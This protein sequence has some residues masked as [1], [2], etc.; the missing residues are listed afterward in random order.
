M[1]LTTPDDDRDLPTDAGLI[2]L[3]VLPGEGYLLGGT[4]LSV[5]AT[6]STT[7]NDDAQSLTFQWGLID[8][9]ED[10]WG[11][12]D[13]YLLNISDQPC[14]FGSQATCSPGP[15]EGTFYYDYDDARNFFVDDAYLEEGLPAHFR[16]SRRVSDRDKTATFTIRVSHNRAVDSPRHD[17]WLTDPATGD[18]Y[19]DFP[20]TLTGDQHQVIGR[21]EILDNGRPDP[22]RWSYSAQLLTLKDAETGEAL[23]RSQER[24]Y[25]TVQGSRTQ[26]VRPENQ[27]WPFIDIAMATPD[28]VDEGQD[29]TFSIRRRGGNPLADLDVEVR[30][31]EPNRNA[32]G[33]TNPTEQFHTVTFA[34]ASMTDKFVKSVN[35]VQTFTVTVNDDADFETSDV[36]RAELLGSVGRHPNSRDA[37]QVTINKSDQPTITLTADETSINEG[38][39]VTFT[40]TRGT[41][42]AG[43]LLVGVRVD[44]PG[45]FL[46]GDYPGDPEGVETP[47]SVM[48]A[49]GDTTKTVT[50]TPPDDRRDIADS[51]L[52]FTVEADPGYEILGTNPQTVQVADND[53]AP[54]VQISFNH[55]EVAEGEELILTIT[56]I[57]E[58][59]NDLEIPML[60]GPA[61]DQ[62]LMV[63][64]MDP[65]QSE[66]YFRYLLPDDDR[67]GPD[68]EYSFTLQPENLEFWTP[69]GDTTVSARIVDN[70]PYRVSVR[71]FRASVDEGQVIYYRVEHDGYTD[72]P[73]Q[74]K[75]N[76]SEEGSAVLDGIL[77][78]ETHT[79]LAGTSGRTRGTI[80][81]PPT[82]AT[83]T[84]SSPSSW[85]R[86]PPT[87]SLR[88]APAP[89]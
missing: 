47:T 75:V 78:P 23:P 43:D 25:W 20:L 11:T 67:K 3:N 66:S 81:T 7:D 51:S 46:Q 22:G 89:R 41:N 52:T 53:V 16:V 86:T 6:I 30:T 26:S 1:S 19:K 44:D 70:D 49:D 12:G 10:D 21:I 32:P 57:G 17:D 4:G 87:K 62:H 69:T 40:L 48:F 60:G 80:P 2:T 28:P 88:P 29:V 13:S 82:A 71:T 68:A 55:D 76:H 63:V 59:K 58:D 45:K 8:Y 14:P 35:Q 64:G 50:I 27:D 18:R 61:D 84:P 34:A 79:I 65:G 33:G 42:L 37:R 54:Q 77:G 56:R 15:A 24:Q 85:W 31:W 5:S 72:E 39:A 36:L 38:E 73:L 74:V 9:D 83:A